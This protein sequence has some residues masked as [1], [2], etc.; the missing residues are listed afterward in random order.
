MAFPTALEIAR[1]GQMQRANSPLA[2]LG[3]LVQG[4]FQGYQQGQEMKGRRE[5]VNAAKSGEAE[6]ANYL[7]QAVENP[8]QQDQLF[9]KAYEA[10]PEFVSKFMQAKKTQGEISQL[11]SAGTTRFQAVP[12]KTG[13]KVFDRK[14]G[15][16]TG[17]LVEDEAAAKAEAVKLEKSSEKPDLL[18]SSNEGQ[19]KASTFARRMFDSAGQLETLENDID[20]TSRV[21]KLISGGGGIVSEAANRIASPEEQKYATAASDFVTAQL[22]KESGAAIGEDEFEQK[23]REFFPVPGDSEEQIKAKRERRKKAAEDMRIESGGLYDELYGEK[24]K[25]K[26]NQGAMQVDQLS[27]D[28]LLKSLGL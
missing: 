1:I 25:V 11:G 4:G 28:E 24:E 27:D 17:G 9:L 5:Q 20:P 7:K 6:A 21:I 23:Y 14:F 19:K 15:E 8:D 13:F 22:R 16:F 18:S 3:Q 2:Q 26:S 10:S 12:F